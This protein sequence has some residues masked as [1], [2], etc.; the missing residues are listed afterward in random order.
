MNGRRYYSFA[1]QNVRFF[2]LDSNRPDRAQLAWLDETLSGSN[3]EWKICY[4][5]HPIYSNGV[6]HGPAL[7]LRV[8]L[9]PILGEFAQGLAHWDNSGGVSAYTT[10][11]FGPSRVRTMPDQTF[12][13]VA[14]LLCR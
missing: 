5:H 12:V 4:F 8:L 2:A 10:T 7:E 1:V 11:E 9:E 14:L 6:R 13:G 3:E